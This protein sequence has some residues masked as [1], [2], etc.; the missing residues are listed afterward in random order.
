M[1]K[2]R[3]DR[4]TISGTKILFTGGRWIPTLDLARRFHEKGHTVYTADSVPYHVCRFS[5]AVRNNFLV[6]SS[7]FD[8]EGFITRLLQIVEE[9]KIDMIIPTFEEIFCFSQNHDRFPDYC[10][11]FSASFT[12][13][14]HLHNKWLFNSKLHEMGIKA[15]ESYLVRNAKELREVPLAL[16]YILKPCYSRAA[17]KVLKVVDRERLRSVPVD[18]LNPLVAQEWVEGKKF[19]SYSIVQ[20]GQLTAHATYA[21]EFAIDDSSCLNFSAIDHK[22]VERWVTRF[23]GC[24]K[25]T[26]QLGFDFIEAKDGNL[27]AIECNP[28]ATSGVHLFQRDDNLPSAFLDTLPSPIRPQFGFAKQIAAGMLMYGWRG[29][30]KKKQCRQF[31]SRLLRAQDVVFSKTD[32]IPFCM[33]PFLFI[34]YLMRSLKLRLPIPAMFT[35][36]IDWNDEQAL[37]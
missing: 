10:T 37:L 24:E 35:F 5:G 36:D 17:A 13:L 3:I 9:K 7:R 11:L 30:G 23:A 26:G 28:R 25:L 33:Q 4:C 12:S 19:C 1:S 6:P 34:T 32:P 8:P 14:K 21:L 27:Y 20:R 15:P 22:G 31:V 16:P 2:R 18:P 29:A